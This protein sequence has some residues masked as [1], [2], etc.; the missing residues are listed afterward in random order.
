[1]LFP[2]HAAVAYLLYRI[3]PFDRLNPPTGRTTGILLAGALLPDVID[4]TLAFS[5]GTLP[6]RN[7][8]HSLL[9]AALVVSAGIYIAHRTDSTVPVVAFLIGYLS[10]IAAD[11]M[12]SWFIPNESLAFLFWP[13]TGY[14]HMD[15]AE[16]MSLLTLTPYT[17]LQALLIL[18]GAFV[19]IRDGTPGVNTHRLER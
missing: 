16:L 11:V 18:L 9:F 15:A 14:H 3:L 4:K 7:I 12:D 13:I 10:H 5:L 2:T 17:I 8:L 6:T 19:W 1:M